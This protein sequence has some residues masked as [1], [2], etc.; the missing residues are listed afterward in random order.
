MKMIRKSI[1]ITLLLAGCAAPVWQKPGATADQFRV[2]QAKCRLVAAGLPPSFQ[3]GP[4]PPAVPG[5]EFSVLA[6]DFLTQF[7]PVGCCP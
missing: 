7:P 4:D 3:V 6:P 1:A 5:L 2:D